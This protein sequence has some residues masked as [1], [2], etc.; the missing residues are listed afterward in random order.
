MLLEQGTMSYGEGMKDCKPDYEGA[1]ARE[2]ERLIKLTN[3]IEAIW[4]FIG[5]NSLRDKMAE[6]MG[7][8]VS[9]Q[10]ATNHKIDL[11]IQTQENDK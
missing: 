8:L 4:A 9:M 5:P 11:L 2:R 10:R 3:L 7:E 1:I 6:L